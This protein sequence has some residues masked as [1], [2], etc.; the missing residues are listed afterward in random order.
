MEDFRELVKILPNMEDVDA[1]KSYVEDE[2]QR[3]T[4]DNN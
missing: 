3:F 4:N 2:I 1:L